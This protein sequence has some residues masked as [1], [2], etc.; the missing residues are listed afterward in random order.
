M[1]SKRSEHSEQVFV[2]QWADL[3]MGKWPELE[4]MFHVPN[5]MK[6][7]AKIKHMFKQAGLRPGCPDIWL[8]VPRRGYNG[9]VIELKLPGQK[10]RDNQV[11]WLD[12]L[13]SQN[14]FATTCEGG[15][16]A[17]ETLTWYMEG[18]NE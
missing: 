2:F 16:D 6:T 14:W 3:Q 1:K 15:D 11:R 4:F 8:P 5:G 18:P 7:T 17:V 13:S 9:L 12:F 10:P